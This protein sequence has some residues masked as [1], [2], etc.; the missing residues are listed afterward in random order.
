[1]RNSHL[2]HQWLHQYYFWLILYWYYLLY[3]KSKACKIDNDFTCMRQ[4]NLQQHWCIKRRLT[5]FDANLSRVP[6]WLI[7]HWVHFTSIIKDVSNFHTSKYCSV[8]STRYID[9]IF[10][11][12]YHSI[13]NDLMK[14]SHQC[15]IQYLYTM[16][17]RN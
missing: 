9:L 10:I 12:S 11:I 14:I 1:M 4:T 17:S 5:Q 3:L 8:L 7:Y 16:N 15:M 6:I 13:R 2:Y